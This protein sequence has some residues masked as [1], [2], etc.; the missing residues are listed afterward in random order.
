MHDRPARGGGRAAARHPPPG[1]RAPPAAPALV[2]EPP[3]FTLASISTERGGR[4]EVG[5]GEL[6]E[7]WRPRGRGLRG[8]AHRAADYVEK[9]GFERVVIALSGGIDSALVA[10]VAADALGPERVTCVSMPSPVLERGHPGRRPRDRRQPRRGLPRDRRSS[11]PWRPTTELLREAFD[12]PRARRDRGEH[13]GPHPRQRGDGAV[14]QVRLARARHRQQVRAVGGLRH[15]LRRHG[16]RLRGPEGRLQG[17]GVPPRALAQRAGGARAGAGA[18]C[19]S[20]RRRPSCAT[21]SAT[22]SRCPPTTC[23]TRSSRAT[24]RRTSTR[25][26]WCAAG[27]PAEDV[28]RVIRMVDRAEYKRRQAPPGIKISTRAFGRDRRL[29]ITNRYGSRRPTRRR[30][31]P[32]GAA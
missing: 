32:P 28:E 17:L 24:S 27:L 19:S 13:A 4:A 18:R 29:P 14:E 8:A 22:T 1:E 30:A 31:A 11:R 7:T 9:N 6:A 3:V 20:A 15:A 2:A 5:P 12:G 23:S 26:S 25:S 21:S 10:L 16:G